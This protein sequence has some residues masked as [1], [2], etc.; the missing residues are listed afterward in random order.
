MAYTIGEAC[1]GCTACVKICPVGAI[2]GEK[3]A[4]HAVDGVLC[5]DCGVCGKVC[6]F[7]AVYDGAGNLCEAFKRTQWPKPEFDLDRCNGCTE[8]V[9]L[10]PAGCLG[11]QQRARQDPTL[12]PILAV[13][14]A[15]VS[16]FFCVEACPLDAVTMK[17]PGRM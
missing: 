7:K 4:L 3:K 9:R 15:C 8:C 5:I 2:S 17:R 10:C 13:S 12:Y 6:N 14:K 11:L 16:C 1:T